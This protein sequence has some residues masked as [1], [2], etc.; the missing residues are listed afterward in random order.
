M[1]LLCFW[2]NVFQPWL[3]AQ[4]FIINI[5]VP[6]IWDACLS[7]N[8]H[9]LH[10]WTPTKEWML[11]LPLLLL[12]STLKVIFSSPNSPMNESLAFEGIFFFNNFMMAFCR[13]CV[14]LNSSFFNVS[15]LSI[16]WVDGWVDCWKETLWDDGR[17]GIKASYR[18]V[19][20][21]VCVLS[22]CA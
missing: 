22:V 14:N 10:G 20:L 12:I 21:C 19:W 3:T 4:V 18:L 8:L 1:P 9:D 6:G 15:R 13:G 11:L 2:S 17:T 16:I 5:V 7:E